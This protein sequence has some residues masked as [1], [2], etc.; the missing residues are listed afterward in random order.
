MKDKDLSGEFKKRLTDQ[1]TE[2]RAQLETIANGERA[3]VE[4]SVPV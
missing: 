2:I 1:C 4:S 3:V